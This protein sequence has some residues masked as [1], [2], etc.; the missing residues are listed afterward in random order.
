MFVGRLMDEVPSSVTLL[1]DSLT[2]SPNL[3]ELNL[4]DNAFG[5]PGVKAIQSFLADNHSINVFKISNCGLGP[6]IKYIQRYK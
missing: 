4:S 1:V 5:P 3:K 2:N 6:V